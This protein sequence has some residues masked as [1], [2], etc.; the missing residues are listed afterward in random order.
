MRPSVFTIVDEASMV[1]VWT[2]HRIADRNESET[3][4]NLIIYKCKYCT[5]IRII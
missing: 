4:T 2:L 1:L 3:R 5:F